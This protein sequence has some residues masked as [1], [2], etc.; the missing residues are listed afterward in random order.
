MAEAIGA[1]RWWTKPQ[2]V[3]AMLA[4]S[5]A[6]I[7][8]LA[9]NID[10]VEDLFGATDPVPL[11]LTLKLGNAARTDR[12]NIVV[13]L[14]YSKIGSAHLLGCKFWMDAGDLQLPG[15]IPEF[16]LAHGP[17]AK[18]LS[19]AFGLGVLRAQKFPDVTIT[20]SCDK[21]S[22]AAVPL[23]VQALAAGKT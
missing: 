17:S 8:A 21:A 4:V 20:L 9:S 6:F 11:S 10:E 16:K 5:L 3:F 1:Q 18:E 23:N 12:N 14:S 22:S 2:A 13:S 7:L 15:E 19:V